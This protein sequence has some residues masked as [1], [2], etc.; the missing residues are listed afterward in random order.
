MRP[1]VYLFDID[2]T[3]LE[4]GGS[5]RRAMEAGF[6]DVVGE[7]GGLA[8][9]NFAGMTDPAI[10]RAALRASGSDP[11]RDDELIAA[12]IDRYL[13]RLPEEIG[14]SDRFHLHVGV[15]RVLGAL[16]DRKHSAIGL[17]TGNVEPGARLKLGPLGIVDAFAF[18]G[19]ASD[20]EDR[21]TL[22]GIGA[23]RGVAAL[24]CARADARVIV[25]GDTPK[26]VHAALAIGAECLAVATGW[27]TVDDLRTAGA[28]LAVADL[29]D[30]AALAWL[31]G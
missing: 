29:E 12:V 2:G 5:G 7:D 31:S 11:S 14:R 23:A 1:T 8:T 28:T 20:H 17:G 21:P 3:L 6:A 27:F 13:A 30:P 24:G 22:V 19:Y 15:P 4:G 18:G 26:D 10:V 9:L 16:G 25:I